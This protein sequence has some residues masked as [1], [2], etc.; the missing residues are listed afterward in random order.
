MR[1]WNS[2][3]P[4]AP[5]LKSRSWFGGAKSS[6]LG[7]A[8]ARLRGQSHKYVWRCEIGQRIIPSKLGSMAILPTPI[9]EHINGRVA[10]ERKKALDILSVR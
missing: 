2:S 10:Q 3:V 8:G 7:P 9:A 5:K 4:S 1:S 6:R